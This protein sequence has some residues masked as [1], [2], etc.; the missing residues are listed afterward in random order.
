MG[1]CFGLR[2]KQQLE[3]RIHI[4][5]SRHT[6]LLE[7]REF[8]SEQVARF[9]SK[10]RGE[11]KATGLRRIGPIDHEAHHLE[12]TCLNVRL[13]DAGSREVRHKEDRLTRTKS[14]PKPT[15]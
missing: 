1:H 11:D 4:A 2:V 7:Y 14:N 9:V 8:F 15:V 13:D 6:Q 5:P 3:H 10:H 12:D